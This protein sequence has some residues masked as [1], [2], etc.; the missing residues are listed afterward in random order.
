MDA[1]A[2]WTAN[3][4]EEVPL[5]LAGLL[6]DQVAA[7]VIVTRAETTTLRTVWLLEIIDHVDG[8]LRT[9]GN[10]KFFCNNHGN[11]SKHCKNRTRQ[12]ND[13]V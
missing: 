11:T 4:P 10:T 2:I 5:F 7:P 6:I 12:K 3:T 13:R 8:L 9:P 1:A